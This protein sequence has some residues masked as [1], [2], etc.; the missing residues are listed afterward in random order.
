MR[1]L[2]L[3]FLLFILPLGSSAIVDTRSAGYSKTFIDFKTND[4]NYPLE[5]KRTYNS[6][7]LYNGL[8]GFGWCSNLETRLT[9]LPDGMIKIVE[10][11]GG[12]E[13]FYQP[14]GK[15]PDVKSYVNIILNKLKTKKVKMSSKALR[16]LKNDLLKSQNL[17][18]NFLSAL[19]I[20]GQAE[21][22][23]KYYARGRVKEY[24]VF[25]SKG[26]T[27]YLPNGLKES[28][29]KAGRLIRSSNK[30]G[31]IE[32]S[33]SPKQVQIMNDKGQRL[34]L[35][36]DSRTGKAKKA[37]YNKKTVAKYTHR[38]QDLIKIINTEGTFAHGY[39]SLHNL[40]KNTYPDKTTEELAYN[41][42]KDWVVGFKDRRNCNEKYDYGVNPKNPDH[43]FSTVEK[44]C[45]R[46]IVNKSKY[47][48]WHKTNK[49]GGKY[50]HRARARINGRIKTDVTYHPVFGTP[51]SFFKNGV[52]TKR[53]YYAN[54][55]LK[56]KDNSYQNV[57]YSKY[58]QKCRKPELVAI[59]YKNP[60]P[61]SKQKITRRESITFQFDKKCQ[62]FMA[63]K[64]DDEW[65]KIGHDSK[66]RM[67]SME[68]QSRKKIRL[69][70]HPSF[71]KPELIIREG[72]GSLRI[73]YDS[74][75]EVEQLKG[76]K[77]G[78]TVVTQVTSVFNSFLSTLAPVA[79]EMVI[80]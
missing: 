16:K 63:K 34:I 4:L 46:R 38:G 51:I 9:V 43:Y 53:K 74:K 22:G 5:I 62:L 60:N 8:F 2:L 13:V 75:G 78:P 65:I 57:K 30:N 7:S 1:N 37:I 80:L 24:V 49:G 71:N 41:L 45:G 69:T 68:D 48:F 76:L 3:L 31:K 54:G 79:E 10:C 70:W 25:T 33:W 47:E 42:K 6:R 77:K 59:A 18:A 23:L 61:N 29:N 17:R 67:I 19:D 55:F 44:I 21:K 58:N 66:G 40:T 64:S 72:V 32:I 11:G 28:F 26:Y 12:M 15:T 39:D 14:K 35:S 73:V 50:L 36:L 56:E 52:R 27:R 20:K